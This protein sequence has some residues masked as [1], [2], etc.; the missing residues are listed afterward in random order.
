[1]LNANNSSWRVINRFFDRNWFFHR[2]GT[3]SGSTSDH[4]F[5]HDV[6]GYN[7]VPRNMNDVP[8]TGVGVGVVGDATACAVTVAVDGVVTVGHVAGTAANMVPN[9]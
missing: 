8:I 7:R 1:M 6:S 3:L 5:V 4:V 2:C 9:N